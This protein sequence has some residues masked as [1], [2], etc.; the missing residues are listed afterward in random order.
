MTHAELVARASRWLTGMG[1]PIVFAELVTLASEQPDAIGWRATGGTS[2]LI[3][4]KSSRSDFLADRKKPHRQADG[5]GDFRYFMCTPGLIRVDELPAGWGLLYCHPGRID[6]AAGRHP[7]RYGAPGQET[8][9]FTPNRVAEMRMLASALIRLRIDLGP[10]DFTRRIHMP[11]AARVRNAE[12][13]L[14]TLAS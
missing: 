10:A 5:M 3:E 13:S 14:T 7:K 12:K 4:C 2:Y 6:I 1:C 8:F 11:Y 9:H